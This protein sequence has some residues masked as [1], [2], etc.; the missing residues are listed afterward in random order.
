MKA[1]AIANSIRTRTERPSIY[2]LISEFRCGYQQARTAVE[3]AFPVETPLTE[4]Q[5]FEGWLASNSGCPCARVDDSDSPDA[6]YLDEATNEAWH[7]WQGRAAIEA[8]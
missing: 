3:M 8:K 2:A 7:A 4:R 5:L 1:E 6:D